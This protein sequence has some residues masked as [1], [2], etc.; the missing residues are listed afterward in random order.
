MFG[1]GATAVTN[2]VST[3]AGATTG[4]NHTYATIGDKAVSINCSNEVSSLTVTLTQKVQERI[5]GLRL[6]RGGQDSGDPLVIPWE[7]DTGSDIVWATATM[8]PGSDLGVNV[9]DASG[10]KWNSDDKGY[11]SG[12]T[13]LT[14]NLSAT[15]DINSVDISEQYEITTAIGGFTATAS[16]ENTTTGTS[17]TYTVS[18]TI[19]S[20]VNVTLIYTDSNVDSQLYSGDWPSGK[21]VTFTHVFLDGGTF[22]VEVG[23]TFARRH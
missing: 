14:V 8:S 10:Y 6:S 5:T 2:D 16:T 13:I 19:G 18:W 7:V 21:T 22:N 15:N 11:L 12:G 17:I 23:K 3:P 20:N 9:A 4:Y 1:D